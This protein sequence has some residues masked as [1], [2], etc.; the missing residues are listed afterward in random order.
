MKKYEHEQ[1]VEAAAKLDG[2]WE[3]VNSV[4]LALH[5]DLKDVSTF[6]N[7]KTLLRYIPY[8]LKGR[9]T[10]TQLARRINHE[11]HCKDVEDGNAF[12]DVAVA[13]TLLGV[14]WKPMRAQAA[15]VIPASGGNDGSGVWT[16]REPECEIPG[17]PDDVFLI[18]KGVDVSSGKALTP[19]Q[20]VTKEVE[21]LTEDFLRRRRADPHLDV[22]TDHREMHDVAS[23]DVWKAAN[24]RI[25]PWTYEPDVPIK[26][27]PWVSA[28]L[29]P[30]ELS[31]RNALIVE[32]A[33]QKH[34]T[35]EEAEQQMIAEQ[36]KAVEL[37]DR[38]CLPARETMVA[39]VAA[40]DKVTLEA[41]DALLSTRTEVWARATWSLYQ[42]KFH[43]E[44]VATA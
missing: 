33:K 18:G 4:T 36:Q 30:D 9:M 14:P 24:S 15:Y 8:T 3:G 28:Q 41:A 25:A 6:T 32:I 19:G 27:K 34:I 21:R 43:P 37:Y 16:P 2:V 22:I 10:G 1:I 20:I 11:T 31:A 23:E 38:Y 44:T 5:Y 29:S 39:A 13:A 17:N 12:I 35:P 40:V 7:V 42:D 26:R